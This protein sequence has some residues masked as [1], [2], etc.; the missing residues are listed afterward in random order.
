M[1]RRLAR[2][3]ILDMEGALDALGARP[4]APPKDPDAIKLFIGQVPKSVEEADL[5]VVF[6]PYGRIHE[7]VVLKDRTTG[8]HKGV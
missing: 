5:R 4:A 8:M 7:L 1:E 2:T 6:E 3:E